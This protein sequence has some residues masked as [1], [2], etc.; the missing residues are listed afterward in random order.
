MKNK[1]IIL[2]ATGYTGSLVAKEFNNKNIQFSIAGRD[3]A[4][5]MLLHNSLSECDRYY[6]FN[7]QIDQDLTLLDSFDIIINCIG[8]YN[9]FSKSITKYLSTRHCMYFDITGEQSFVKE[10]LDLYSESIFKHQS[11]F[12]HSCSFESALVGMM[13]NLICNKNIPYKSI[14]SYYGFKEAGA[15]PGTRFTMKT[16]THFKQYKVLDFK[17]EEASEE[18]T[19]K[20]IKFSHFIGDVVGY[21]TPFP[22]VIFSQQK[23]MAKEI[24][25]Y[26]LMPLSSAQMT[27]SMNSRGITNLDKI[28]KK[29]SKSSFS[30]PSAAERKKQAFFIGVKCSDEMGKENRIELTGYDMYQVTAN[31]LCETVEYLLASKDKPVGVKCMSEYTD[32]NFFKEFCRK[33]GLEI[34]RN[35]QV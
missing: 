13:T 21:F 26:T 17:L 14:K 5:T 34:F 3:E 31:L 22:E 7:S 29:L 1:I 20:N 8:P 25:S 9:I 35:E 24:A 15:S 18:Q 27:L 12:C 16:H 30:G 28:I 11:L 2:G 33:N 10:S 32:E 6:Q 19:F 23:F 4:K